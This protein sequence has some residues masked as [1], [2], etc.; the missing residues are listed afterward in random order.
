[1][2]W[3]LFI[4]ILLFAQI[5]F[6]YRF[7]KLPNANIDNEIVNTKFDTKKIKKIENKYLYGN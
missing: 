6:G 1:M 2:R 7:A 3:L 5:I 4:Q